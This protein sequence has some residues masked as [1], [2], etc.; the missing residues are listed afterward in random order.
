MSINSYVDALTYFYSYAHFNPIDASNWSLER[1]AVT[2]KMMTI[3]PTVVM[4]PTG[5]W[6][7]CGTCWLESEIRKKTFPRC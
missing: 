1:M 4:S 5:A 6:S 3:L 7:G 2:S